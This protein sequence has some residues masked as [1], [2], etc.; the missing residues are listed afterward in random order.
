MH[1]VKTD[2]LINDRDKVKELWS[3]PAK[4][5]WETADDP[6]IRILKVTPLFAEYWDSPEAIVNHVELAAAALSGQEPEIGEN[7]KVRM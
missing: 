2:G 5:W 6:N 7:R 4:A 3:T 1:K